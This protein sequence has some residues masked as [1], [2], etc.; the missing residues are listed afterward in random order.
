MTFDEY[1][2]ILEQTTW[3]KSKQLK[4]NYAKI[5]A[6]KGVAQADIDSHKQTYIDFLTNKISH[7][8]Y[9]VE[10]KKLT[11]IHKGYDI[12]ELRDFYH[13]FYYYF[14]YKSRCFLIRRDYLDCKYHRKMRDRLDRI[15]STSAGNQDLNWLVNNYDV[16]KDLRV[17]ADYHFSNTAIIDLK[18]R[19]TFQKSSEVD[20]NFLKGIEI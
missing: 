1:C 4:M 19:Q 6:N 5:C 15:A 16:Y 7:L 20:W 14:F 17:K 18:D 3:A 10:N 12:Y 2:I 8:E 13:Y 11:I 9:I